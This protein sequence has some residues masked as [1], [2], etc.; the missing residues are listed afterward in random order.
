MPFSASFHPFHLRFSTD[1]YEDKV[2]YVANVEKVACYV[3]VASAGDVVNADAVA[4]VE[5]V[6]WDVYVANDG[7]IDSVV[8]VAY[9]GNVAL[10]VYVYQ[11]WSYNKP[12]TH[13]F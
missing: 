9:V 11:Y 2:R 10:I 7:D 3:D 12:S 5:K 6:A 1:S 8:D 4:N 13:S